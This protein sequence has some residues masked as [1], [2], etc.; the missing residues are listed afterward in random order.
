MQNKSKLRSALTWI[1]MLACLPVAIYFSRFTGE[2]QFYIS[3][4]ICI[5]IYLVAVFIYY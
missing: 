2:R 1:F 5:I 4:F 3:A